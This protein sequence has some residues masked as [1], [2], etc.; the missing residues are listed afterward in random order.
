MSMKKLLNEISK[1]SNWIFFMLALF[2][3]SE[4]ACQRPFTKEAYLER[5]KLFIETLEQNYQSYDS[6]EWSKA[7]EMYRKFNEEWRDKFEDELTLKDKT[8]LFR[9]QLKYKVIKFS[10]SIEQSI[11][12]LSGEDYDDFKARIQSYI[13]NGMDEDIRKLRE[14]A[15]RAGQIAVDQLDKI[16]RELGYHD[17]H[18]VY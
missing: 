14:V 1:P 12:E 15:Q 11:W 10:V 16:L 17:P 5:Y 9:Y 7:D 6:V 3:Y 2:I 13:E 18:E 4:I 8:I